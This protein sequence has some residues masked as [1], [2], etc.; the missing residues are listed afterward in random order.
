MIS[1]EFHFRDFQLVQWS[2]PLRFPHYFLKIL[3]RVGGFLQVFDWDVFRV[4]S[5]L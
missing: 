3:G 2:V 5:V 1:C 4:L